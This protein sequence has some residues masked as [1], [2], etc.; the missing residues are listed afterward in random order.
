MYILLSR[1][2][3]KDPGEAVSLLHKVKG[4]SSLMAFQFE[5]A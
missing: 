2:D 5:P 1:Y 3:M 4:S